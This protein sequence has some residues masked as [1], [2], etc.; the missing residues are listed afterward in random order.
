MARVGAW[1]TISYLGLSSC[2]VPRDAQVGLFFPDKAVHDSEYIQQLVT[3][4]R[5][6]KKKGDSTH[7]VEER[8]MHT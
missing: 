3:V 6:H 8:C 1:R 7:S 4:T 5:M 2:R